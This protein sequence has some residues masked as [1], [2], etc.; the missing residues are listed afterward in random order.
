MY[1]NVDILRDNSKIILALC[2]R[3]RSLSVFPFVLFLNFTNQANSDLL[4]YNDTSVSEASSFPSFLYF[5]TLDHLKPLV[6]QSRF[7]ETRHFSFV[8]LIQY[9]RSCSIKTVNL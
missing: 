4:Q 1:F 9:I 7:P 6:F 5:L 3:R 8:R 2:K